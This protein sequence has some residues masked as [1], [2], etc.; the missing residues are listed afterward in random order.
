M[1]KEQ[2][3]ESSRYSG[4]ENTTT[5][6]VAAKKA[7]DNDDKLH[8]NQ[9]G[10]LLAICAA[11]ACRRDVYSCLGVHVGGKHGTERSQQG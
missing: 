3:N 10:W 8:S 9:V 5:F 1:A 2:P 4:L 11:I 6:G 7:R